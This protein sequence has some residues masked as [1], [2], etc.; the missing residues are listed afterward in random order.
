[1]EFRSFHGH[2]VNIDDQMLAADIL[3]KLN[4]FFPGWGWSVKI[5]SDP[6]GGTVDIQCAIGGRYGM[7][8]FLGKTIKFGGREY[9]AVDL[10]PQ[11]RVVIAMAGEFIE[12]V[13]QQTREIEGAKPKDNEARKIGIIP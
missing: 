8:C 2:E 1:M 4:K 5:N 9:P 12:R 6:T 3:R 13:N 11:R 7:R 10:D